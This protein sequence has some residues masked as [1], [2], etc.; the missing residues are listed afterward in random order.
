MVEGLG[1]TVDDEPR[2]N[3][4]PPDLAR[5]SAD[6]HVPALPA[7]QAGQARTPPYSSTVVRGAV[8]AGMVLVAL[9]AVMIVLTTW[10]NGYWTAFDESIECGD[11]LESVLFFT[12][13]AMLLAGVVVVVV[14]VVRAIRSRSG[15]SMLV[16]FAGVCLFVCGVASTNLAINVSYAAMCD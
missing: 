5:P 7:S 1:G 6:L 14:G 8:I 12:A 16:S 15:A 13:L 11:S 10:T 4:H 9:A 2:S 3:W